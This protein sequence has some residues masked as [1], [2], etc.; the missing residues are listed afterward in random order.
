MKDK[1][2]VKDAINALYEGAGI[3]TQFTG[4]VNEEV[5]KVFGELLTEIR[6]CTLALKWVPKPTGGPAT[7]KWIAKNIG[8]SIIQQFKDD[9]SI[10]CAKARILQFQTR[11]RLAS[12]G[13]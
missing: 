6:R 10:T 12:L 11:L 8:R 13:G 5:A 1:Q 7:I 4:Q 9:I 2:Q 3:K